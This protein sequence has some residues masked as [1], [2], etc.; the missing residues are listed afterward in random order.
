VYIPASCEAAPTAV[1]ASTLRGV[2]L[3][4]QRDAPRRDHV[5][6]VLV[7][8]RLAHLGRLLLELLFFFFD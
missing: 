8:P 2:E 3:H 1:G 6:V 4:T 7:L 5:E